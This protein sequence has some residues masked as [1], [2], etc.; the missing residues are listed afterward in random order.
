[1]KKQIIVEFPERILLQIRQVKERLQKLPGVKISWNLEVVSCPGLQI[2][3][4]G[5]GDASNENR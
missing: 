2:E 1:M 4:A 3:T 5:K